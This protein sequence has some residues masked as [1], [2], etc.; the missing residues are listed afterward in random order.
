MVR[1]S[2]FRTS[3]AKK[4][5]LLNILT[6]NKSSKTLNGRELFP[7]F[8]NKD[9]NEFSL[10]NLFKPIKIVFQGIKEFPYQEAQLFKA[11][12]TN[13]SHCKTYGQV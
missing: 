10:K 5:L 6:L 3:I 8:T 11:L 12:V 13:F 2:L 7:K 4:L 1:S 9:R